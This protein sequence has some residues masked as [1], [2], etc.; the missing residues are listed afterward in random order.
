VRL[1]R[2]RAVRRIEDHDVAAGGEDTV[3]LVDVAVAAFWRQ[4]STTPTA[5]TRSNA[6]SVNGSRVV[7][8]SV[9]VE[10]PPHL[11]E[12]EI[13]DLRARHVHE[14]PVDVEGIDRGHEG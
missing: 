14:R 6:P 11:R 12:A 2:E 4:C 3:P 8:S 10:H 1:Q 5:K 13:L 9:R 7:S